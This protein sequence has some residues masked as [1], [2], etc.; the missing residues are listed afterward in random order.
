MAARRTE[1]RDQ[2]P[3]TTSAYAVVA[4]SGAMGTNGVVLPDSMKSGMIDP[5]RLRAWQFIA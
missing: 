5:P 1:L 3:T 2:D 4:G